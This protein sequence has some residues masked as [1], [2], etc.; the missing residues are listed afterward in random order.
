MSLLNRAWRV[1]RANINS[2]VEATEDPEKTLEEMLGA[3]QRDLLL[4]RQAVAHAIATQKRTERE[5][6]QNQAIAEDWQ[7]RAELA[8]QQGNESNA[9]ECLARCHGYQQTALELQKQLATQSQTITQLRTNLRALEQKLSDARAKKAMY[10]ARA[11]SAQAARRMQEL[12]DRAIG[13]PSSRAFERMEDRVL[14]LEAEAEL[15]TESAT[16]P[17]ERKFT[18]L[19][20]ETQVEQS[21]AAM[22][23]KQ[24]P[25]K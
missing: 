4:L 13:T 15:L 8:L 1:V 11:R 5:M 12:S 9:R 19:E 14:Q 25:K 20:S 16:S 17:L 10:I 6:A 21:L 2:L 18:A 3:M 24:F 23:A 7:R 22:R